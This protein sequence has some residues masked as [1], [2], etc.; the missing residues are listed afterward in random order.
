MDLLGGEAILVRDSRRFLPGERSSTAS[1]MRAQGM[2]RAADAPPPP[3]QPK[4]AA[5]TPAHSAAASLP[6]HPAASAVPAS[7]SRVSAQTPSELRSTL[8][9]AE[10]LLQIASTASPSPVARQVAAAAYMMEIEAQEEIARARNLADG[11]NRAWFA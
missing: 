2:S 8:M 3:H 11:G 10:Q 7:P 6:S 5:S 1:A 4:P 9:K